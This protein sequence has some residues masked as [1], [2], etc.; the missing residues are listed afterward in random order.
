MRRGKVRCVNCGFYSVRH[1]QTR[2]LVD[3]ELRSRQSGFMPTIAISANHNLPAYDEYSV[4]FVR[5]AGFMHEINRPC[6]E[7]AREKAANDE[8]DCRRFTTWIQGF[9]PK[10]HLEMIQEKDR[11]EWQAKQAQDQRDFQAEQARLTREHNDKLLQLA[12]GQV[13]STQVYG[14][15]SLRVAVAAVVAT[16]VGSLV[17]AAVQWAAATRA[18]Q[19]IPTPPPATINVVYPE[20]KPEPVLSKLLDELKGYLPAPSPAAPKP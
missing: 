10:E 5:Q 3:A 11:L 2:E 9:S 14:R 6:N 16:I 12:A 1:V 4:C 20:P 7:A 19:P 18:Q 17:G 15:H 13:E 8:R